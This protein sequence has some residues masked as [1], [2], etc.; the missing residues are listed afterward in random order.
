MDQLY[1]KI[2]NTGI[3]HEVTDTWCIFFLNDLE[4]EQGWK[5]H[6]S[7]QL[8]DSLEIFTL[9]FPRLIAKKCN[10]KIAKNIEVLK[11]INSSRAVSSNANKFITIYPENDT[12]ARELLLELSAILNNFKSP[13]ILS[14][15]QCGLHSPVHYRY[16]AY[17]A[18][19]K[20]DE[21]E[22]RIVYL[23]KDNKGNYIEDKRLYYP[24]IPEGVEDLFSK[25]EKIKY[26][27]E[28]PKNEA[29]S[30]IENYEFKSILKRSNRGNVYQAISK[31]TGQK[32][33]IKQVRPFVSD[34]I[35][36]DKYA[37]D[38][39]KNEKKIMKKLESKNY[40]PK[41]VEDFYYFDDYFLVQTLIEAEKIEKIS[42]TNHQ[43]NK[44][45]E[46]LV[47]KL[48]A[49]L[50]ELHTEGYRIMDLSPSNLLYDFED[51]L[52]LVDLENIVDFDKVD[53]HIHTPFMVNNDTLKETSLLQ[54][55]YFALC[56]I[57]FLILTGN[58]LT[59]EN[60]DKVLS[61]T[62]EDKIRQALQIALDNRI[63]DLKQ[64]NWLNYLLD[65]SKEKD[66]N[67]LIT[68]LSN[69]ENNKV[70]ETNLSLDYSKLKEEAERVAIFLV[71]SKLNADL[72]LT[73]SSDFGEF[74]SP[75]SFQHGLSGQ[76]YFLLHFLPEKKLSKIKNW[77]IDIK[78]Y[79][80]KHIF[81]YDNSLLFGKAGFLFSILELYTKTKD[82]EY[83]QLAKSLVFELMSNYSNQTENDFALGRS[84]ILLS[85]MKYYY[86]FPD[87]E[88]E[89]FIKKNIINL[90]NIFE[91]NEQKNCNKIFEYSFAHGYSGIA[92]VISVYMDLF[93]DRKLETL[94][95]DISEKIADIIKLCISLEATSYKGNNIFIEHIVEKTLKKIIYLLS[96]IC[97]IYHCHGVRGC[98]A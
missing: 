81:E 52:F 29:N 35:C 83:S 1:E 32:V 21:N 48:V 17:K 23:I 30:S 98:L 3:Y 61:I 7:A 87:K 16:G 58:I 73:K 85:I 84:G 59:F 42:K 72:R 5:L 93:N 43:N 46:P 10:F 28:T 24:F 97:L 57:S 15:F 27:G 2:K 77:I 76:I 92:Y 74:V 90:V 62:S 33:I 91:N 75:L 4:K 89:I 34:S 49:I 38:E 51:N 95:S 39:I 56:M 82:I 44:F 54:Q 22:K 11:S 45:R 8:K 19:R 64:F 80:E 55:D 37:I 50:N 78:E 86:I 65:L 66:D 26:F 14:D 47:D 41:F 67:L 6:I 71:D 31:L 79:I 68:S 69:F 96:I 12:Q 9:V 60:E 88:I 94:V 36:G 63:I 13:R 18:I 70:Y 25:E 40:T 53:R 20:Y